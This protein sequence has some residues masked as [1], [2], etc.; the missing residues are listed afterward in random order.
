MADNLIIFNPILDHNAPDVFDGVN[1]MMLDLHVASGL[2]TKVAYTPT[3]SV[4]ELSDDVKFFENNFYIPDG[5][6]EFSFLDD[7]IIHVWTW[8]VD[9]WDEETFTAV[10]YDP[11]PGPITEISDGVTHNGTHFIVPTGVTAFTFEDDGVEWEATFSVDT[12]SFALG[13][14]PTLTMTVKTDNTGTSNDDQ[15]TIQR[16][17]TQNYDVEKYDSDGVTLLETLE[18][19]TGN[20]TLSWPTE[21]TY[22]IKIIAQSDGSGFG[23]PYYNNS[24]D[25]LKLLSVH[26]GGGIKYTSLTNSYYG[27]QNLTDY[28]GTP[29]LSSV[30]NM[31]HAFRGCTIFNSDISGWDVS[32]V[33]NM[34]NM[35][36]G[37]RAFNANIG[38]WDVSNVE[39]TRAMFRD[40]DVFNADISGWDV[41]NVENM[42]AMFRNAAVFNVDISGWDVSSVTDMDNMFRLCLEF[43]Q[44]LSS[45][46]VT[47]IPDAPSLF[48][49]GATAWVLPD[50][51]PIWGTCP[52]V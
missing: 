18:N 30:T 25:C 48:D 14:T 10:E 31:S 6:T 17:G 12:W 52:G 16:F 29:D 46:C 41:S 49:H 33:T 8:N 35:F 45:W 11:S 5:I 19:Q 7:G 9:T 22:V 32:N 24:G 50:S 20:V 38:A 27:C 40:T 26:D 3:T 13:T 4:T 37:A 42:S 21:G 43:N 36:Y 2:R 15:F 51:R 28:T 34:D 23:H 44:N 47:L 1:R 39:I